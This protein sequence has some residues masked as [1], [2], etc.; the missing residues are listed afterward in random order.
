MNWIKS[1]SVKLYN[2][3]YCWVRDFNGN[4]YIGK[5]FAESNRIYVDGIRRCSL[6][7]LTYVFPLKPPKDTPNMGDE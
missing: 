4:K 3:Q 6:E 7:D 5:F 2:G 1:E